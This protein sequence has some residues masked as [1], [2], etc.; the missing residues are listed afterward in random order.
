MKRETERSTNSRE[1]RK[2]T[3]KKMTNG[4][5]THRHVRENK[6]QEREINKG[7]RKDTKKLNKNIKYM[8]KKRREREMKR[9]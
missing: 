9:N 7:T 6:K 2:D 5:Y 8:K 4:I 3:K 1:K